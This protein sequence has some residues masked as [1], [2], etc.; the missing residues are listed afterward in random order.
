MPPMPM[1]PRSLAAMGFGVYGEKLMAGGANIKNKYLSG[2]ALRSY[3]NIN[4]AYVANKAKVVLCPYV[5]KGS[6]AR[7]PEQV[8]GGLT[9]KPPRNDINAPDLYLP[10]VGYIAY[11]V[12]AALVAAKAGAFTPDVLHVRMVHIRD[13]RATLILT[14]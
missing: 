5:L 10:V 2:S 12:L 13:P 7:I 8:A 14:Q 3:F 6:W 11:C 4:P 1:S 9:Y